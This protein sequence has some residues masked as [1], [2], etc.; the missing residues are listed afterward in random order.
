MQRRKIK[1]WTSGEISLHQVF[2]ERAGALK[3]IIETISLALL[4]LPTYACSM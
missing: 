3:R 1:R 4:P 2:G